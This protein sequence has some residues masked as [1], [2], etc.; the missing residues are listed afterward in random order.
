MSQKL[1]YRNNVNYKYIFND[2]CVF[3]TI[4]SVL[5]L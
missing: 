4:L 2:S 1:L 3:I 5:S